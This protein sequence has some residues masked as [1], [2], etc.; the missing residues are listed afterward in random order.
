MGE[1]GSRSIQFGSRKVQFGVQQTS[2]SGVSPNQ[3]YVFSKAL[4]PVRVIIDRGRYGVPSF[5]ETTI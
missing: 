2:D 4:N 5:R 3:G 1:D